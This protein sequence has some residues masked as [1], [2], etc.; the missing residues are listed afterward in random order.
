MAPNINGIIAYP[1]LIS[2]C[3]THYLLF[4]RLQKGLSKL[5]RKV[6]LE[7]WPTPLPK[8]QIFLALSTQLAEPI[9]GMFIY[10]FITRAVRRTGFTGR[11]DERTGYRAGILESIFYLTE[12]LAVHPRG[13]FLISTDANRSF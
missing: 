11:D 8:L 7:I 6:D 5:L 1:E 10:H 3:S 9:T 12:S 2:L 13:A 4:N